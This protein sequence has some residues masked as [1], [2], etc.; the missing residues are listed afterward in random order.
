MNLVANEIQYWWI[1]DYI[2]VLL[3]ELCKYSM[4]WVKLHN[5]TTTLSTHKMYIHT[6]VEVGGGTDQGSGIEVA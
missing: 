5:L 1:S 4:L 6:V 2:H 3:D